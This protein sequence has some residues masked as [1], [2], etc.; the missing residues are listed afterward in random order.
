[1][2]EVPLYLSPGWLA[3]LK[4]TVWVCGTDVYEELIPTLGAPF[5]RGGPV[6]DPGRARPGPGPHNVQVPSLTRI[7]R[8]RASLRL[9]LQGYLA[10]KKATPP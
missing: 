10:H 5:P 8:L 7:C 2:G 6:Q 9:L 1:M 3:F 4:L